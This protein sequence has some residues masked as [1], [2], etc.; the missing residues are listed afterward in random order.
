[1]E[2]L[3]AHNVVPVLLT[4]WCIFLWGLLAACLQL[5]WVVGTALTAP[6]RV[7]SM[8]ASAQTCCVCVSLLLSGF[9]MTGLQGQLPV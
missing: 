9:S 3:C 5:I 8:P 7:L 4:A 6:L 1:M 2:Q